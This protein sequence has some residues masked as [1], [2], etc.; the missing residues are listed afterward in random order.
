MSDLNKNP[1]GSIGWVDLTVDNAEQI[2]I[3]YEDVIGFK[4]AAISMGEYDDYT[5][6][7][8]GN[9]IPYAGVCNNK[10]NNKGLPPYWLVYFNVPDIEKSCKKVKE[11]RGELLFEPKVMGGYGKYCVIKDPA[12]AYCALFEPIEK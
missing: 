8:P 2:K 1:A 3:F 12:G 7:S 5:M 6:L 4:S 11:L 10:G 9:N